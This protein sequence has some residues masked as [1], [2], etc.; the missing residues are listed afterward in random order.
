MLTLQ[1]A[2]LLVVAVG[3]ACF[4]FAGMGR[5]DEEVQ[6]SESRSRGK[7]R[8]VEA[9][10][11]AGTALEAES[12]AFDPNTA[13]S[14]ML[15]RLGLTRR[16]VYNIYKYRAAGGVFHR[17]EDVKKLYGLTVGQ[18]EHLKPL[19]RIGQEFRY[20]SE[21]EDAY[22]PTSDG[23][24]RSPRANPAYRDSVRR[25]DFDHAEAHAYRDTTQFPR[26]LKAGEKIDLNTSDTTA[27]K[28]VP[29]IGSYYA[30]RI[31]QYR[32]KLGGFVNM[33]QLNEIE[34]LPLGVENYLS[35]N[36]PHGNATAGGLR[37]L[38]INR[39]SFREINNH[40]Y[41]SYSQTKVIV[42]HIR[43]FGPITSFRDL[44]TYEEFTS[45]DF[46]RLEPYIDFSR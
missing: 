26:K 39:S 15:L 38:Y 35:L 41:L 3:A 28:R 17:P 45:A 12:F 4:V 46:K 14:T 34:N 1:F 22:N 24:P 2:L 8:A 29:G 31:V 20:L 44:S 5:D 10:A 11:E 21:T 18:W 23:L 27:L 9:Y 37:K 25:T 16:Q 43:Q 33:E 6:K 42:N 7:N 40:P 19:I 13:D 30:R 32:E 36:A